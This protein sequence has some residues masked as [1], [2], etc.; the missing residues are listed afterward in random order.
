MKKRM[1]CL[2]CALC[3]MVAGCAGGGDAAL[4]TK[5]EGS[6]WTEFVLGE[7]TIRLQIPEDWED[8]YLVKPNV[9]DDALAFYCDDLTDYGGWLFSI[10]LVVE[11][12]IEYLPSYDILQQTSRGTLVAIYPTDVQF[13]GAPEELQQ[14]YQKMAAEVE[15]IVATFELVE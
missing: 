13:E 12:Q 14:R 15:D 1:V 11:E 7:Y 10:A 2:L 9:E 8:Y 5:T 4:N 3:L 6:D